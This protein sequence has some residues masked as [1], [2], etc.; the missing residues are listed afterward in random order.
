MGQT[1]TVQC[2]HMMR[3]SFSGRLS[4]FSERGVTNEETVY[5][6]LSSPCMQ[7]QVIVFYLH[8]QFYVRLPK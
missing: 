8:L 5:F 6:L 2:I 7:V 1:W 3:P 4:L